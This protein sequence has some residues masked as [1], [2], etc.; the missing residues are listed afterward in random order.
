[1]SFSDH[2]DL[3]GAQNLGCSVVALLG[4]IGTFIGLF[5]QMGDCVVLADGSGCENENL[6][7]LLWFPGIPLLFVCIGAGM[8][9]FFKRD[10]N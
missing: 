1:M 2:S 10:K 7:R 3:S 8:I 5:A 9:A 4:I 6:K